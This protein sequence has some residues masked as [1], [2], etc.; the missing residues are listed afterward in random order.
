MTP[1]RRFVPE[2]FLNGLVYTR[3]MSRDA[4]DRIA[5]RRDPMIPPTRLMFDGPR[6][7]EIFRKNGEEFLDYFVRLAGLKPDDRVLDVGC[8]IGRKTLPLTRYLGVGSG[9]VGIDIVKTGVDWCRR[10]ISSRF[11]DFRFEQVDV[12]NEHYN[13]KG[14]YRDF[15]FRFPFDDASFD[16]VVLGSVFTHML[17]AGVENYLS[18]IARVLAPGGRSLITYFLVNDESRALMEAGKSAYAMKPAGEN[19]RIA[20]P[21]APW[22]AVG[23]DETYIRNLYLGRGFSVVEPVHYGSWCGRERFTSFQDMIVARRP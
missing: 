4:L 23:F 1:I 5:G 18:E 9:Y 6:G 14:R 11:P 7:I 21:S 20:D 22:L 8:G 3:C 17:P 15:E 16:F 19:H 12:H 2:R 10:R 13:P